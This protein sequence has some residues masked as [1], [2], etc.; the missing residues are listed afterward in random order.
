MKN[1]KKVCLAAV[2][3][4][5]LIGFNV[6]AMDKILKRKKH[7]NLEEHEMPDFK[8]R[9][10]LEIK[11][12]YLK[13]IQNALNNVAKLD[14]KI[15]YLES[16]KNFPIVNDPYT[17]V[18]WAPLVPEHLVQTN[19]FKQATEKFKEL[20]RIKGTVL[21]SESWLFEAFGTLENFMQY[22][23]GRF[24]V[25]C[26]LLA[27]VKDYFYSGYD[28]MIVSKSDYWLVYISL[29]CGANP[30]G[31][32]GSRKVLLKSAQTV[33]MAE[34]LIN[35]GANTKGHNLLTSVVKHLNWKLLKFYLDKDVKWENYSQTPFDKLCGRYSYS[36]DSEDFLRTLK[37]LFLAGYRDRGEGLERTIKSQLMKEADK[38]ILM[39]ALRNP[40]FPLDLYLY[41]LH[42]K[43]KNA[44]WD[45]QRK[46]YDFNNLTDLKIYYS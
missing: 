7:A 43:K 34:L 26:L 46:M 13:E 1:L 18:P 42:P 5:G 30:D 12:E 39:Q 17:G 24:I 9:K 4:L 40:T 8:K 32:K 41:K 10:L 29:L 23:K 20:K 44:L 15:E 38:I 11:E 16:I 35:C 6:C 33:E 22:E 37:L 14:A 21:T 27:G 28:Y 36:Y 45:E 3:F 31:A 19:M 2:L 25:A